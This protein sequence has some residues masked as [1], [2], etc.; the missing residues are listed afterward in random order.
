MINGV[1][2]KVC[3]LT[4]Q[5]DAAMADAHGADYLGFIFY[6]K[7]ARYISVESYHAMEAH[8]PRKISQKHIT[9]NRL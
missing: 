6:P 9:V 4:S 1:R 8:L 3:G 7:S 2:F 5:V